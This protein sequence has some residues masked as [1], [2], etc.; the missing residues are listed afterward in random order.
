M[1]GVG[2]V[3]A[4]LVVA[5]GAL[6]DVLT[7]ATLA[8]VFGLALAIDRNGGRFAARGAGVT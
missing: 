5:A 3:R 8:D 4:G 1:S 7:A 2:V 6:D